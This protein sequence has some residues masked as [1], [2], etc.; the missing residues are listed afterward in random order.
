MRGRGI[1]A[2]CHPS[3]LVE[4][5]VEH[6]QPLARQMRIPTTSLPIL[7][8][9]VLIR[10]GVVAYDERLTMFAERLHAR[11]GGVAR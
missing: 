10:I 11:D 6:H 7:Q 1:Y 2:I 8:Q 9:I 3:H 4:V 5:Y